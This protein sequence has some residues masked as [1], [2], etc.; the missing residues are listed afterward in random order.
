MLDREPRSMPHRQPT[1]A[2]L[3]VLYVVSMFPCWSETFIV[4][5]IES[6]LHAG[7]EVRIVSLR[8]CNE[9]LVQSRARALLPQVVY[10]HGSWRNFP[11]ALARLRHPRAVLRFL[12]AAGKSL[13]KRPTEL[14]K[15]LI[16]WYR[17]NGLIG[18]LRRFD[19][20]HVHA[21]W[22]TYPS[23][24]AMLLAEQLGIRFSFTAHAHDI[25]LHAQ[26]L[27]EK[28]TRAAFVATISD[29]NRRFLRNRSP[30]AHAARLELVRCGI[31][32]AA[33]VRRR[34]PDVDDVV[35]LSVGRL[36]EIKGFS[37]LIRACKELQRRK[38]RFK[39]RIVG[40]GP[41]REEL[42]TQIRALDLNHR[43]ELVGALASEEV[44]R[45]MRRAAVFVLAS[46]PGL[47]GNMDGIPV[48]LME[49]MV[50]GTPVISTRVSGIP[51]LVE[52]GVTGLLVPARDEAS[53]ASAI[54]RMLSDD[55]LRRGCIERARMR[56]IGEF[57]ADR[58]ALRLLD[59]YRE[60]TGISHAKTSA[61]RHG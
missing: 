34:L 4:R 27:D 37:T 26:L 59:L 60:T 58:E 10:P 33:T 47:R 61:Y 51:E 6:L 24:A 7:A 9:S 32:P 14:A 18:E 29:F 38:F 28:I 17:A 49:A 20:H 41:L 2:G 55:E 30:A 11:A 16:T 46:Q 57:N 31:E 21:H 43:V 8:R 40:E 19:P 56:V 45:V 15:T 35:I 23:T 22:A 54:Q 3:R 13:W 50:A 39:C 42:E 12:G 48:V 5:E 25:F 52:D 44:E 36:D 1:G 53:L